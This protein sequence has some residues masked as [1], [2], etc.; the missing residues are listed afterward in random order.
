MLGI[1]ESGKINTIEEDT[2]LPYVLKFI[3]KIRGNDSWKY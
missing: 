2:L 3:N 1:C